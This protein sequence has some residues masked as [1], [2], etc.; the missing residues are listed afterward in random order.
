[1]PITQGPCHTLEPRVVEEEV[2]SRGPLDAE[3]FDMNMLRTN[4]TLLLALLALGCDRTE[5]GNPRDGAPVSQTD[6]SGVTNRQ[7][8][9]DTATVGQLAMARCD[10]EL[11]CKNVGGGLKYASRDVCLNEMR[12]TIA[13]DL[14]SY[15]CPGGFDRGQVVRC[16]AAIKS[17]ECDHPFDT[18]QRVEKCRTGALCSK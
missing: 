7:A 14:N 13:N 11:L 1:V 4:G 16:M 10:R 18:L 3:A 5:T 12:G 15:T 8:T 2:L 17:E 9:V 6:K